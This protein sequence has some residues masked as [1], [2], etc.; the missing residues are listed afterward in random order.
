MAQL[1]ADQNQFA[2]LQQQVCCRHVFEVIEGRQALELEA[3]LAGLS[4]GQLAS[5]PI[6]DGNLEYLIPQRLPIAALPARPPMLFALN[7]GPA[8]R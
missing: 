3:A 5:A 4:P 1:R 8:M 2:A 6:R 7:G